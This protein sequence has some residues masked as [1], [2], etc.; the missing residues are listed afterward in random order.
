MGYCVNCGSEIADNAKYCYKCGARQPGKEKRVIF[1]QHCGYEIDYDTNICPNC[2]ETVVSLP[3]KKKETAPVVNNY[4]YSQVPAAKQCDKGISLLL[5]V[6]F[7][8]FGAHKFYEG[9]VGMGFLYLF[10]LGFFGI[11]WLVDIIALIF[12]PNTYYV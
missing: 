8:I 2:G 10:T 9:R 5:C 3:P 4:Y 6:F 7:G 11:G 1:C 12:K